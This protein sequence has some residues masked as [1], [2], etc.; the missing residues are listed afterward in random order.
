MLRSTRAAQDVSTEFDEVRRAARED[1]QSKLGTIKD[2]TVPWIRRIFVIGL[3]MA[4]INQISGVNAIMYYGTNI[5]SSSGFGGQGALIANV[6]NGITSVV[7]VIVGMY[8]MTRM[9]RKTM[10]TVG[11]TGTVTW[12]TTAETFPLHVR[13]IA[14]GICVFVLLQA[15]AIVWVRRVVPETRGRAWRSWSSTSSRRLLPR[16][17]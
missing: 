5:L 11:L 17:G 1:Y 9:P 8:L 2:L 7:A 15:C 10:L 14:M 13:G 6:L 16:R 12:L 3:G 4:V